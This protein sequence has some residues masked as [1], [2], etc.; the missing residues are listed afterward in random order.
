R[1]LLWLARKPLQG[2][3]AAV[4]NAYSTWGLN[5]LMTISRFWSWFDW[6]AIDG[7]VDGIARGVR[8]VG[9]QVRH[10]QAARLQVNIFYTVSI[11]AVLLILYLF[12]N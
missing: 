3:D 12:S 10:L 7:V 1:A 6:H 5:P 8:G 9:D 2:A 11:V 4:N